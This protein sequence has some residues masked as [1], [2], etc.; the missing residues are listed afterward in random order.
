[1]PR[2]RNRLAITLLL[3][4]GLLGIDFA[5]AP[6]A[7]A[8]A[9]EEV[10][11]TERLPVEKGEKGDPG[12]LPS[13][14]RDFS[15]EFAPGQQ[16][17]KKPEGADGG[18][19]AS[20]DPRD[21]KKVREITEKRTEATETFLM[22]D[23]ST[24][25]EL[26]V[27]PKWYRDA[28]GGWAKVDNRIIADTDR[29]G[30]LR[31]E[32]ASWSVRFGSIADGLSYEIEGQRF[33]VKLAGDAKD[34]MPERDAEEAD[35]I[36]YR[37]VWPGVDVSYRISA[38]AVK[39]DFHV[40]S[41]EAL[42]AAGAFE[43][44][45]TSEGRLVPDE[46]LEG[47]LR[48]DWDGDGKAPAEQEGPKVSIEPIRVFDAK[49]APIAAAKGRHGVDLAREEQVAGKDAASKPTA[50]GFAIDLDPAW[51]DSLT[52][53]SFPLVVDPTVNI[54]P[55]AGGGWAS[56][57]ATGNSIG[58][59]QFPL[60]GDPG[61]IWGG[62]DEWRFGVHYD[63]SQIWTNAPAARVRY[64]DIQF[65][66][67]QYP[68]PVG[69]F[70]NTPGNIFYYG[71]YPSSPN[72]SAVGVCNANAWSFA[73]MWMGWSPN[74]CKN[75]GYAY[76]APQWAHL[77]G[78]PSTTWVET[79]QYMRPWVDGQAN[80][81]VF[82]VK[83]DTTPGY[84]FHAVMPTLRI[85]WD[86]QST[87]PA[88]TAPTADE[89][90]ATLTPTFTWGTST[91]P[92]P[93]ENPPV[94]S[95]V[96]MGG[97]PVATP[98]DQYELSGCTQGATRLW[99]TP[100]SGSTS[101]TV[102]AGILSDGTTYYWVVT[103]IGGGGMDR[104]PRCSEVRKFTVNRRLGDSGPF[105]VEQLG[106]VGINLI[107]GNVVAG[108]ASHTYATVGGDQGVS[109]TYN[110]Q[111][112]QDRGLRGRYY[113]GVWPLWGSDPDVWNTPGAKFAS[114]HDLD[115]SR[116]VGPGHRHEGHA[117]HRHAHRLQR[118]DQAGVAGDRVQ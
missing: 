115:A 20:S 114:G 42:K 6:A 96:L 90:V 45:W 84:T 2:P 31:T 44:E 68:Q 81:G 1:M 85:W 75:Y 108:N 59:S 28:K 43:S 105:P 67:N 77:A 58:T 37:G 19:T 27:V 92:D 94:Y 101:A 22:E 78:H 98:T 73:G 5:L 112:T 41:L 65:D 46:M 76:V 40:E 50:R 116:S 83:I 60:V 72:A 16:A 104:Y 93:G 103:A 4:A 8:I 70:N 66:T 71:N 9:S 54:S 53:E 61:P 107:N 39:E 32:G 80:H 109:F 74:L 48:L 24:M 11:E 117:R 34:V 7:P 10:N 86:R 23:G 100:Y 88:L 15:K 102:P 17:P 26:S 113:G 21:L 49:G 14:P 3:V 111:R 12:P 87:T 63:Y 95:M 13:T 110:S 106:P 30:G 99:T 69:V 47:G 52:A 62:S 91:D 33:S 56:Y 97:K 51:V 79:A 25:T 89:T 35:V 18:P 57:S 64:S 29:E 82:G 38:A 55:S 118:D 36:W